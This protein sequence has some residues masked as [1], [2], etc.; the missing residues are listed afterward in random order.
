MA[1]FAQFLADGVDCLGDNVHGLE[2]D[3]D[4]DVPFKGLKGQDSDLVLAISEYAD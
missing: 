4:F 2:I 1:L 3:G